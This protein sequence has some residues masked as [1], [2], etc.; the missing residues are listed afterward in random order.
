MLSDLQ[1]HHEHGLATAGSSAPPLIAPRA[2]STLLAADQACW[3]GRLRG[4]MACARLDSTAHQQLAQQSGA[5]LYQG[6]ALAAQMRVGSDQGCL[7]PWL[8]AG[9]VLHSV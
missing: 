9:C 2:G 7:L 5:L 3:A 6:L 8:Q 4:Q 1:C